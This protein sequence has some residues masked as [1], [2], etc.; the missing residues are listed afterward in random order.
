[1]NLRD[2]LDVADELLAGL[3]EGY[4]RSAVSRAYYGAFHVAR[5]LFLQCGFRVPTAE[6]AHTYLSLRL[7]NAE[8]PDMI[9]AGNSLD[10]LRR[11][12][13]QADYDIHKPFDSAKTPARVQQ[14][15]DII[16]MLDEAATLP[17]V[18][19]QI[20]LAMRDYER[21]V[22]RDVTWRCRVRLE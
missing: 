8:H 19:A 13:N 17:T 3:H 11:A 20:T 2:F 21:D 14:S 16:R 22:L 18:V 6:R 12:R 10:D 9:A 4:W 7:M 15:A 1:M 5:D